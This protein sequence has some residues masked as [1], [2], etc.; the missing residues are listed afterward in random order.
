MIKKVVYT[1]GAWDLFHT[2][3]VNL[4][5]RAK[6]IAEVLIVG[7]DTDES[8][9]A[10][11]GKYPVIP[12][13]QRFQVVWACRWV[14]MVVNNN[15]GSVDINQL[16]DLGIETIILGDDWKN[17]KVVGQDEAVAKGI[18]FIYIPY[19][20]RVSSTEIKKGIQEGRWQI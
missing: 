20:K 13:Y 12:F 9:K 18:E 6:R 2:G 14:D 1:P 5:R 7:V 16:L 4:L 19:T 8:I 10:S 15:N 17:K 3:H 11:K